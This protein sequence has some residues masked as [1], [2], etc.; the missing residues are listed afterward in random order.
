MRW[1]CFVK[2]NSLDKCPRCGKRTA[3][4]RLNVFIEADLSCRNLSK[5]GIRSRRVKIMG[6]G[7]DRAT[8]YCANSRCG[9]MVR[10]DGGK[11]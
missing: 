5:R 4:Q 7:W 1:W 9:W 6:A 2:A 10:L 3:R 8:W 11:S